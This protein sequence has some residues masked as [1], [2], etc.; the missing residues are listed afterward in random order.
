M[1]APAGVGHHHAVGV[2]FLDGGLERLEVDLPG[3]LFA[4]PH[5][6]ADAVLFAVVEGKVLH[7]HMDAL[8]L[9][10]GHLGGTDGPGQEAVLGIVLKV[11]SAIGGAV[12][13]I[14]RAV[15]AGDARL[16][17]VVSDDLA[18]LRHELH[19]EG[20]GH[21]ILRG[22][23]GGLHLGGAGAQQRGGEA[24]GAVLVP[25]AGGLNGL[26]RHSPVEGVADE[27]YHLVKGEL[28]QQG[29]PLGVVKVLADEVI[30]LHA[31]LGPHG[32]HIH[33]VI[34]RRVVAHV[35]ELPPELVGEGELHDLAGQ[36]ALPVGTAHPLDLLAH[37]VIEVG[38]GGGQAVDDGRAVGGDGE[39]GGV[40]GGLLPGG[41]EGR[42][43]VGV[44]AVGAGVALGGQDV[45][46][47]VVGVGG[48]G[49]VVG[50]R[51]QDIGTRAVGVVGRQVPPVHGDL[52]G[53]GL[54]G[55][56]N[57][58]LAEAHQ[59]DGRLL[60]AV[61][62]VVVGVRTLGIDLHGLFARH[63]AGVGDGDGHAHKTAH[64][65][66]Q[67]KIAVLKGSVAQP[68]AEG[69]GHV[70]GI[71][72]VPGISSTH[73]LIL[74]PGLVVLVADVDALLVDHIGLGVVGNLPLHIALVHGGHKVGHGG[75]REIVIAVGIGQAAGGVPPP[76][77]DIRHGVDAGDAHIA[78]PQ[79]G[80]HPI[81]VVF[82]E[83]HLEGVGGVEQH[84]DLL[85]RPRRLHIRQ[86]LHHLPLI[87]VQGQVVGL[88]E[89]QIN[90]LAPH[91]GEHHDGRV[92]ILGHG[93][94]HLIG[95]NAPGGLP[96]RRGGGKAAAVPYVV[97]AGALGIEVPQRAVD[98]QAGFLQRG[99]QVV[100]GGGVDIARPGTAVHQIHRGG[101]EAADLRALSQGKGVFLIQEKGRPLRL[102][103]AANVQ[104]IGDHFLLISKIALEILG[105]VVRVFQLPEGAARK[106]GNGVVKHV[107]NDIDGGCDDGHNGENDGKDLPKQH[108]AA[109]GPFIG[110][111][112]LFFPG[113]LFVHRKILLVGVGPA[114]RRGPRP[115]ESPEGRGPCASQIFLEELLQS[116]GVGVLIA[117]LQGDAHRVALLNAQPH[118][119]HQLGGGSGLAILPGDGNVAVQPFGGLD[120]QPGGAGVDAH[121]VGNGVGELLHDVSSSC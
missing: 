77:Q 113:V 104:A 6:Q 41:G 16:Q 119:R 9:D 31:V 97:L 22:K 47:R 93:A 76:R 71:G 33:R 21:H 61:L 26:H 115:S 49:E 103:P 87:L 30:Q 70:I 46:H 57:A 62:P 18:H 1:G 80:V 68:V 73:D 54:T 19:V 96:H 45:I 2:P 102:H 91:A 37:A 5:P 65:L 24:L 82:Q 107:H 25:G 4:E 117:A 121:G 32:G 3:G 86:V 94:L 78:D 17:T 40:Q 39:G 28:I 35:L 75:G 106:G 43:A 72:I 36:R 108:V 85:D 100:G 60:H 15:E 10:G 56:Q 111:L 11:P 12:D 34:I 44:H 66:R 8:G 64:G 120:Q 20:G 118:Q 84:H 105:V 23:G 50:P 53:L 95:V 79:A 92:A 98:G 59:L 114:L 67:P 7:H 116:L 13:V 90:A 89:G 63:A 48:G 110:P 52:Q 81:L 83:V 29:L 74:V 101:G 58:G 51:L 27:R 14:A 99:F 109:L 55:L 38:V 112:E 69:E 42:V 88:P